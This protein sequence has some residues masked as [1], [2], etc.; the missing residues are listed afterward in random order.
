MCLGLTDNYEQFSMGCCIWL[1]VIRQLFKLRVKVPQDN[2]C[3]VYLIFKGLR[4]GGY[5]YLR[6]RLLRGSLLGV[7]TFRES[8]LGVRVLR[9][10]L[11]RHN[12]LIY[13]NFLGANALIQRCPIILYMTRSVVMPNQINVYNFF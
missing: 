13:R 1:R 4:L 3:V 9:G 6:V 11:L 2:T 7:N 8:L 5:W 12:A 10:R